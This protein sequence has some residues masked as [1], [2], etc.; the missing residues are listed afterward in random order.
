M[1]NTVES[2]QKVSV[3]YR[4]TLD[5]GSEFDNSR[6]RGEV[7]RVQ[8]GSGQLIAGFDTALLGMTVGEVKN[9]HLGAED[10]YGPI[11][12]EA[13][14]EAPKDMFPPDF[15]FK[16][17]EVVQGR[18]SMGQ[19]IMAKIVEEKESTVVLDMNHPLAGKDLN[20]EIELMSIDEQE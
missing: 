13:V 2:G 18:G 17:G 6:N 16:A 12:E 15:T 9:I 1:T 14:Q 11:H 19:P 3:H 7:M 20:F 5:D 8:V 10:A 4:G